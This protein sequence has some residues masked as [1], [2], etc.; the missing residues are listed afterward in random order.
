MAKRSEPHT[1]THNMERLIDASTAIR[2]EPPERIDFLHT[3]QC[4]IGIPYKNP[5][6]HV[7]EWNRRQGEAALRIEAGSAIDPKTCEF[8]KLSLPYGEKPRLVLIRLASEAVRTR[9]MGASWSAKAYSWCCAIRWNSSS[10]I[11]SNT[12]GC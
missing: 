6:D 4:Q 7:R 9:G 5:G 10:R 2:S 1:L 11:P 8:V 3:I 12:R